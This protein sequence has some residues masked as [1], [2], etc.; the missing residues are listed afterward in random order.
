M[1]II[2][3]RGS[4]NQTQMFACDLNCKK[5]F[6]NNSSLTKL[7]S[8]VSLDQLIKKIEA[9][10]NEIIVILEKINKMILRYLSIFE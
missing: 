3:V 9:I 4:T 8:M 10:V 5:R 7:C 1:R 6:F 2:I